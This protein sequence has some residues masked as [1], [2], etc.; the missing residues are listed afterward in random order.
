MRPID[1]TTATSEANPSA[2]WAVARYEAVRLRLPAATF[3]LGS[4]HV[5]DLSAVAPDVDGFVLDAFG[6]LNVG[7][8][9]IPGAVGRMAALRGMGKRLVVLSN[10]ASYPRPAA[11]AKF[12]RLGFDFAPD[13]IVT[14]RDVAAAA[15]DRVAPG[16]LWGGFGA[17][18]DDFSDLG[19]TVA[20]VFDDAAAY[21]AADGFLLLSSA[22]WTGVEE[23]RLAEALA[24]RPRP[25]VVANPDLVAP[26]EGGLSREPGAIAHDLAD[27]LGLAPVFF[28]KPF[29]AAFEEA[30]RRADRPPERLAMVGDTLHTDV[31]GGRAAGMLTV[32][33]TGHGLL[34]DLPVERTIAATGIVPDYIVPTT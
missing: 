6:V 16:A 20:D 13:E 18:G 32:L 9:A 25:L 2:E 12:R 28:G 23:H 14:S 15:L 3:P 26:R 19:A 7:D 24:R 17:Q 34:A 29:R 22:R 5:A 4:R 1:L 21:H 33:V 8:T 10:A 31:L 30:A 11:V 27:A